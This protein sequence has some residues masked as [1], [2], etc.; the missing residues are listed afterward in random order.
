MAVDAHPVAAPV[1]AVASRPPD[2]G[3]PAALTRPLV[4]G[5]E[6]RARQPPKRD[7]RSQVTWERACQRACQRA[8]YLGFRKRARN[9]TAHASH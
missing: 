8:L 1:L 3:R 4:A 9:S 2:P 7:N 5:D 6:I